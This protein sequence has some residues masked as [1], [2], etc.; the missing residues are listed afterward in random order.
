MGSF[1]KFKSFKTFCT[2]RAGRRA[3]D[4]LMSIHSLAPSSAAAILSKPGAPIQRIYRQVGTASAT[5]G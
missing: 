4:C 1:K 2:A 5:G 3:L